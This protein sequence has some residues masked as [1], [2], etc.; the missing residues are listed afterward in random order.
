MMLSGLASTGLALPI[1]AYFY[2]NE[3]LHGF[4]MTYDGVMILLDLIAV[5]FYLTHIPEKWW[6]KTFDI[7]VSEMTYFPTFILVFSVS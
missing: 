4:S 2:T 6:P 3:G 5:F 1:Y 7:W